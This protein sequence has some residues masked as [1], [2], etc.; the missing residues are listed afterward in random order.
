MDKKLDEDK[1]IE[2]IINI[3]LSY[4]DCEDCR[5]DFIRADKETIKDRLIDYFLNVGLFDH[6]P[7]DWQG[8]NYS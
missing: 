2:Q 5:S 6:T 1:I 8:G 3:V 7:D 4:T